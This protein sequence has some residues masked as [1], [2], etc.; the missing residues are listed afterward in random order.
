VVDNHEMTL[1]FNSDIEKAMQ[2]APMDGGVAQKVTSNQEMLAH[3][4]NDKDIGTSL[5]P[6]NGISD[7]TLILPPEMAN[8]K[9]DTSPLWYEAVR[10][11]RN[12]SMS[13]KIGINDRHILEF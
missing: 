6:V 4:N 12:R 13:E 11:G 8:M 10:R 5:T 9:S 7:D 1:P 3:D 2:Y